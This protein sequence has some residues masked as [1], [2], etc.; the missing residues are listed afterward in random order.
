[1]NNHL[2]SFSRQLRTNQTPWEAKLWRHLRGNNIGGLKFKRQV[3]V[4]EYIADFC[5][6]KIKLV[7]EVDGGHHNDLLNHALDLRK[8]K[9]LKQEGYRV[10]RFWN[11]EID[12]NLEGVLEKIDFVTTSLLTSPHAWGEESKM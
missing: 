8:E 11:N 1:M 12:S 5:C 10:M 3:P 6:N 9:Y 2:I 4:G 7:I